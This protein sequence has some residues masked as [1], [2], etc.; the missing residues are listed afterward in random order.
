MRH[1]Q[2]LAL[3]DREGLGGADH[4]LDLAP[5]EVLPRQRVIVLL[6]ERH[7]VHLLQDP[8][9]VDEDLE[10]GLF[11]LGVELVVPQRDVDAGLECV[12][13]RLNFTQDLV[14][15]PLVFLVRVYDITYLHAV[16]S[17]K[18]DTLPSTSC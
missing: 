18:K 13:E 16:G 8:H 3:V 7:E 9:P 2:G 14:F 17:E 15:L 4:V 10:H 6:R 12:V 5:V 1:A 11:G